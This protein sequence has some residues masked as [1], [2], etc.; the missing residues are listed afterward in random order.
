MHTLCRI[1][2]YIVIPAQRV[3]M[4]GTPKTGSSVLPVPG[5]KSPNLPITRLHGQFG[6]EAHT[7]DWTITS[8]KPIPSI[9][10][11]YALCGATELVA[12]AIRF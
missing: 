3:R 10:R 12:S 2:Y 8:K 6:G 4:L 9:Y 1:A 5:C 7:H 11:V